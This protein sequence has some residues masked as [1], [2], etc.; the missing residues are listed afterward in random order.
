MRQSRH[1]P[2]MSAYTALEGKFG[3]NKTPLAPP[4]YKFVINEKPY[5]RR[6]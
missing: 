3:L 6:T 4:G 2:R 5:A 1:N